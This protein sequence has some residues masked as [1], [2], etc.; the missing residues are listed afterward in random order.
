[1]IPTTEILG[2]LHGEL[3]QPV[4]DKKR[5]AIED[6]DDA[7]GPKAQSVESSADRDRFLDDLKKMSKPKAG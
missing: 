5:K 4:A 2:F 7:K 3:V 6:K 1:M